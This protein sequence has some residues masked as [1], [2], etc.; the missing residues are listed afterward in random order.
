MTPTRPSP[1]PAEDGGATPSRTAEV[2]HRAALAVSRVG[3]T[4]VVEELVRE[5]AEILGVDTA[6]AAV[7]CDEARTHMRT[8][9]TRLDGK[10]LRSF[11][12]PLAGSPCAEVVGREFH[13]VD[14]GAAAAFPPGTIFGAKGMDCYAAYPLTDSAGDPLGL[15]VAMNREPLAEVG[16]A[17]STLKIFAVRIAAEVERARTEAA[18]SSAALAVS[19]A[20]GEAVFPEL[21]RYLATILKA[22]IAF[23]ALPEAD[24]PCRLRMLAFFMDGTIREN[25]SYAA[26]GTPCETV[27]GQQFRIYPSALSVLFPGDR[28]FADIGAESYAGF[29]LRD[30]RGMPLGL[31]SVVARRPMVRADRVE[32]ILQI[33]AVRA[34]AEIERTRGE[35]ALRESET[36]YRAIFEAA[37]DAIFVHD[38]ESGAIVDVN[39]KACETYG[40][41][42][43]EMRRMRI[44]DVSAN[45]PPY[46]DEEALARIGE[47]KLGRTVEF[48]WRRRN[49]DGSL[50][51]DEVRLKS[52]V[53][54]GHRRVLAF[55][56]EITERKLAEEALR[57][58][59][60]QYRTIFNASSDALIL[61]DS[62]LRRVDVNPAYERMYGW[63][64]EESIGNAYEGRAVPHEYSEPRLA[65]VRRALAGEMCYAELDAIRK[66]GERFRAEIHTIPMNYRGQPHVLAIGRDIT[67]RR[68]AEEE[69]AMLEAQLRQAQKMEAIG[70][71]TGGVAHDFNNILTSVMGYLA[72]GTERAAQLGDAKLGGYLAQVERAARR[73]R[74]LI[75]QMLAFSRGQRSERVPA[76]LA[77]LGTDALNLLRST[78]PATIELETVFEADAPRVLIDAVQI[79]QVLLNLCLNARD[80]IG[81]TGRI[82]VAVRAVRDVAATCASCRGGVTGHF[83]E[84]AVSDSGPGIAP[85]VLDRMFEPFF[86]TKD[87]GRGSGMG[88]AMVH[89]IVHQHGGHVLVHVQRGEG[90]T[91]RV[92]LPGVDAVS[93]GKGDAVDGAG[94]LSR[95]PQLH[96]R[97]LVVDDEQMVGEFMSDLLSGWGL[98]VTVER[99]PLQAES[100]FA[101]DPSR[102]DVVVTDQTMPKLTG[103]ELARRLRAVRA[104]LP[105]ILYTGYAD[106]IA[107]TD[108]AATGVAALLRKPIEPAALFQ[109]LQRHLR[110]AGEVTDPGLTPAA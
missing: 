80:A 12:Y 75:A 86:S 109:H 76:S 29:P 18:L 67:E 100:W 8:L 42:P 15:V 25:F 81:G 58:S 85:A 64:R 1:T 47:A 27:I 24:E 99:H 98:D 11:E 63:T 45:V 66:N 77:A 23:I 9:A 28:D 79:E 46:T 68:R 30:G 38:W 103:L 50:H 91:F 59:E 53:I 52:A 14:R 32:S 62:R 7:F 60:E 20:K 44:G 48:E 35:R 87:V 108:I 69:R 56:R 19:S 96:G 102:V 73:A 51:W 106:E 94:A 6:F 41:T 72:L 90:T 39:P 10:V 40:Y 36:S 2:M 71:L 54:G 110:T 4:D 105:V 97:V 3:G 31:I 83:V 49:K 107:P 78:L 5:L 26:R 89:G 70:H 13:Y 95:R 21:V 101:R 82:R 92:L 93:A 22:D 104:D 33:F 55:S 65:L 57:A 74:D 16:L 17:E 37:E 43:A 61:W 84:L 88:L 34:A